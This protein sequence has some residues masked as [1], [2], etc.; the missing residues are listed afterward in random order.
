MLVGPAVE[1]LEEQGEVGRHAGQ[2]GDPLR[3][4]HLQRAPR[5]EALGHHQSATAEQG[6]HRQP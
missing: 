5:G 6:E 4:D 3:S 2:H 1:G